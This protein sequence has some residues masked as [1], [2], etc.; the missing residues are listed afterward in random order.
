[1]STIILISSLQEGSD[2]VVCGVT[3]VYLPSLQE[4]ALVQQVGTADLQQSAAITERCV[5]ACLR[6]HQRLRTFLIED[7]S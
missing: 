5:E 4:L 6:V 2:E 3:A 7:P 1:M